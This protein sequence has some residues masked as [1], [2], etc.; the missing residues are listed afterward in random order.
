MKKLFAVI[1]VIVSAIAVFMVCRKNK[2]EQ[3]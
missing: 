2:E 1:G 3:L